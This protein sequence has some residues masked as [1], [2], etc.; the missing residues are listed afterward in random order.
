MKI[1]NWTLITPAFIASFLLCAPLTIAKPPAGKGQPE[2]KGRP[3]LSVPD[4][5]EETAADAVEAATGQRGK[6]NGGK[7]EGAG[8]GKP[9][10]SLPTAADDAAEQ[11]LE[12]VEEQAGQAK[13]QKPEAAGKGSKPATPK[14]EAAQHRAEAILRQMEQEENKHRERLARLQ[15]LR[16]RMAEKGND[17]ALAQV[18]TLFQKEAERHQR[19]LEKLKQQST[20]AGEQFSLDVQD[21]GQE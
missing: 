1:R 10:L 8:Q 9:E 16:D 13:G 12:A 5:A 14:A 7:P 4:S 11:A 17:E 19:K 3:E 21:A 2:G 20:K 18:D 15:V 6:G